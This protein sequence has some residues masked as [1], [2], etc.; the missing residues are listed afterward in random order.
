MTD[1]LHS[2]QVPQR[3]KKNQTAESLIKRSLSA[4][5]ALGLAISAVLY[6]ICLSGTVSVFKNEIARFEQKGEPTTIA[7]SPTAAQTAAQNGLD[8]D[9]QATHLFIHMPTKEYD[10]AI[11]ETDNAESYVDPDGNITDLVAHP[12]SEFLID[13]HYYLHLPTSFGMVVVAIFGV[14][15]FAMSITGLIAYPKIFKDAF[16]FR[17]SKSQQLMLTD[18]HNRL[19]VWTAPFHITNSL[20][21]AM[22]GLFVISAATIGPLKYN[23]NFEAVYAPVFGAEPEV[24]DTKAPLANIEKAL[25]F[26]NAKH[27][28]REPM[29]VILHEPGTQGQYLQIMAEHSRRLI[30]A[31]KYNFDGA[32][33]FLGTVGSADGTIGQQ[34]ADSAYKIHFG[35]FGGL[36]IKIAFAIFGL[37]L[38]FIIHAGIRIYFIKLRNKGRALPALEGAWSGIVWGAP[39]LLLLNFILVSTVP[40][41]KTYLTYIFWLGLVSISGAHFYI[42][43]RSQANEK[44]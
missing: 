1:L 41:S 32:G 18:L 5:S 26:M 3:A 9:P 27:P 25:Q 30:Y 8:A 24:D 39:A 16:A 42:K 11:V 6:I 15:L 2:S 44:N 13:L 23:G 21:G 12:W 38:L 17:R 36:P 14:F 10:R 20:T 7:L 37:C 34:V 28:N 4:H 19:S 22:I 31:E 40:E 33:E 43:A 35:Q 29:Y